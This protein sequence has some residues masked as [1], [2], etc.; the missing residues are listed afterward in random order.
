[1]AV[2]RDEN[3]RWLDI[4]VDDSFLVGSVQALRGLNPDIED[5]FNREKLVV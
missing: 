1:M 3:V 2:A 5:R 4:A